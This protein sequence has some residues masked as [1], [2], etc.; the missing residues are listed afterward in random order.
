LDPN[1]LVGFCCLKPVR[2]FELG[3]G[4]VVEGSVEPDGVEPGH[5]E[6][7]CE[8]DVI[9]GVP[10]SEASDRPGLV[11]ALDRLGQNVVVRVADGPDGRDRADLCAS[12]A[13]TQ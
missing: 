6:Q 5:R 11:E 9:D 13:L 12:F 2:G 3:R 4:Y 7:R 1:R 8:L 10:G